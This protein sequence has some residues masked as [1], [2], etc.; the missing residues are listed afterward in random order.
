MLFLENFF[1]EICRKINLFLIKTNF[2]LKFFFTKNTGAAF[3]MPV[4]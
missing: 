1:Q 2:F 3:T 4:R